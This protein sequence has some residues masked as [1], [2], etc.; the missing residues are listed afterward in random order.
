M[1]PADPF[2][3]AYCPGCLYHLNKQRVC[4]KCGYE[5]AVPPHRAFTLR[6]MI[7]GKQ[8]L[9]GHGHPTY[10]DVDLPAWTRLIMIIAQ[11]AMRNGVE[12]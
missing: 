3:I 7:E 2:A 10:K 4:P 9:Y 6:E 1:T 11:A 12:I 5:F 8:A